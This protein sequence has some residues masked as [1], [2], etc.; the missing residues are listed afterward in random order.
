MVRRPGQAA[1]PSVVAARAEDC[2]V[3]LHCFAHPE[4]HA[5]PRALRETRAALRVRPGRSEAQIESSA[6]CI[7]HGCDDHEMLARWQRAA[8][9]LPGAEGLEDDLRHGHDST[10]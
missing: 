8:W 4:G 3:G 6:T 2:C 5:S 7:A 9:R 1:K 10:C